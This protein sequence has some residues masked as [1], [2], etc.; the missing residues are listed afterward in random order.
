MVYSEK[1][2][3]C[4]VVYSGLYRGGKRLVDAIVGLKM[5]V[6]WGRAGRWCR[7]WCMKGC[8]E[9]CRGRMNG[10]VAMGVKGG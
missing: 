8:I 1:N 7:G 10:G 2:E 9:R 5:G 4:I 6:F 3:W